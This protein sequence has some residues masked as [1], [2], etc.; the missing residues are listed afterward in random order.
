MDSP[1]KIQGQFQMTSQSQVNTGAL[2]VFHFILQSLEAT[3]SP[4]HLLY[5]FMQSFIC[6]S[7]IIYEE[8][9]FN[10]E[11]YDKVISHGCAVNDMVKQLSSH[12]AQHVVIFITN[13][14]DQDRGDLFVSP[15]SCVTMTEVSESWS[16]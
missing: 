6:P 13:H 8:I 7:E 2:L 4:P 10:M 5:Q 1:M 16:L 3:G 12:G 11:T 15:G 9:V 14:C